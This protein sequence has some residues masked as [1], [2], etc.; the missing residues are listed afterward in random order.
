M[1][2]YAFSGISQRSPSAEVLDTPLLHNC[3]ISSTSL[4]AEHLNQ[5]LLLH[6]KLFEEQVPTCNN[7]SAW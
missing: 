6:S 1:T 4:N 3:T 5:I 2:Q 7:D